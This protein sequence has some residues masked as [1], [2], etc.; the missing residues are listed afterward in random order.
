MSSARPRVSRRAI[1]GEAAAITP[2]PGPAVWF[3]V[4]HWHSGISAAPNAREHIGCAGRNRLASRAPLAMESHEEG[5]H[6]KAR[7]HDAR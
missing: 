2:P 7:T 3:H 5:H 6:N 1:I 4:E